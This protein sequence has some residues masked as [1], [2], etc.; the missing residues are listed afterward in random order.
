MP[1]VK[2]DAAYREIDLDPDITEILYTY[3]SNKSGLIFHTSRNTPHL[4]HNLETRWLNPGLATLCLDEGEWA[5]TLSGA[6]ATRG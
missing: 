3:M 4:Y 2:T 5:G 6:T 1:Y